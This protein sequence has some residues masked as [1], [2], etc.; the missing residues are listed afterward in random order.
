[1]ENKCRSF[2]SLLGYDAITDPVLQTQLEAIDTRLRQRYGM[3]ADRA[4]CGVLD[5]VRPRFAAIHP[6]QITYGASVPKI[7]ILLAH[8]QTHPEAATE[9]DS[10]TRRELGL[11]IKVSSNKLAA[12]FSHALGLKQIQEILCALGFYDAT[13]GG[14]LWIGKHYGETGERFGDPIADHS[15]AAT[16]RACLRFYGLLEQGKLISPEASRTMREIFESPNIRHE[17]N[18]FVKGLEGRNLD[19]IRKSGSWENW[20]HDTAV[21]SGPDRHYIIVALTEHAKGAEYLVD[22]S[23][24]VDEVIGG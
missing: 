15:H 5:L 19:I 21:V 22:F 23:A 12:K 20:Q 13:R 7:G 14:G 2:D 10:Q 24:A 1:M 4:A 6:D 3:T 9:L 17:Q 18:K 8:F 16:A 11:M